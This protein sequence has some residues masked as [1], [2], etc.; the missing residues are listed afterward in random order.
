MRDNRFSQKG[1]LRKTS[2]YLN[3]R[4]VLEIDKPFAQNKNLLG[5]RGNPYYNPRNT[6]QT[7]A[8]STRILCWKEQGSD[9]NHCTFVL[10][11]PFWMTI[12]SV[13]YPLKSKRKKIELQATV[14]S[15]F[16][17]LRLRKIKFGFI[18]RVDKGWI[19]TVKDLESW[20]FER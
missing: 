10:W 4:I 20:R 7:K 5:I 14:L 6:C 2:Y 19:T 18:K 8:T 16:A 9:G 15:C 1:R 13:R 12:L 17:R 11:W 3:P